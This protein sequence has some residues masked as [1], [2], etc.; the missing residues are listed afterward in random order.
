MRPLRSPAV[1]YVL[2]QVPG[3]IMVA[4]GALGLWAWNLVPGWLAAGIVTVWLV[5]DLALYPVVRRAFGPSEAAADRVVG[6]TALAIER[7]DPRG[8]VRLRGELWRAELL[9]RDLSVEAGEPVV[10]VRAEGLTLLVSPGSRP[11]LAKPS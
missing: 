10:V 7:L 8:Y 1:R 9:N 11:G 2:L 3:W 6:E 5:K 4:L